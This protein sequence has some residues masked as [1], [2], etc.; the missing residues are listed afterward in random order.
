ML[1]RKLTNNDKKNL[2]LLTAA[3]VIPF[4]LTALGLWKAYEIYKEQTK[5]SNSDSGAEQPPD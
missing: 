3:I 4:G 1:K 5:E 2:A